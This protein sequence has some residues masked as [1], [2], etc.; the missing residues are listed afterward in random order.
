MGLANYGPV[1]D[2]D[3]IHDGAQAEYIRSYCRHPRVIWITETRIGKAAAIQLSKC[4][5]AEVAE[6]KVQIHVKKIIRQTQIG[7]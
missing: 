6:T 7:M 4:R 2:H 5:S 3:C 1:T